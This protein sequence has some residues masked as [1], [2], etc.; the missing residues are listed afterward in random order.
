MRGRE[1]EHKVYICLFTCAVSRAVHLEVVVE[2]SME[3]FLQAFQRFVSRRSLPR[4]MLSD[5]ATTYLTAA[6]ELQKLV[7][8]AALMENLCRRGVEWRFIPK[9]APW[10][11]GF[12]ERL[13]ALTK[14]ALKKVLG[15]THATLES[16]QTIV[17]EVEAVLNNR[18]LTHT[19]SDVTDAEPI[20]P[21]HL[22]YGRPIVSLTHR[23]VQDDEIDDP[24]YDEASD[25]ERRTKIQLHHFWN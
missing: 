15:R 9:R 20:T 25:I 17:V 16:L 24:T 8:S 1:G 7:S 13:I 2:L 3:C 23:D 18:P 19:S 4:L 22:L 11:G 10:F 12:W 6:E 21:S 5:N 14:A